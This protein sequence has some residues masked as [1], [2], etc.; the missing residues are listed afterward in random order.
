MWVCFFFFFKQTTAYELRISDWSSDVCSS[1]LHK[2]LAAL[3][4]DGRFRHDLYY[5]INVIELRVPPLRERL[6]DLS[7]L[8]ATVLARLAPP[9]NRSSE[10]RR[11]GN[12]CVSTCSSRWS[13]V[14][15]TKKQRTHNNY[16]TNQ[17]TH[18]YP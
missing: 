15:Q 16:M 14:P 6:D 4:N 2:D 5:R 13:P 18:P 11:V 3:V 17:L 12:E 9:Q 7:G 8:A 1:D 10:E